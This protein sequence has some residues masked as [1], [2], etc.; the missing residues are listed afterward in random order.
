MEKRVDEAVFTGQPAKALETELALVIE[1]PRTF[2]HRHTYG[3]L[4]PF[5]R[6]LQEGRLL[7]TRCNNPRCL[8]NRLW[9]PARADCPDCH[10]P[11]GWEEIPKPII[12]TIYTYTKVAYGGMGLEISEPYWQIDIELPGVCTIFKS[13]L[14]YGEPRIGMKVRAEFQK[15]PTNT[16]L[17]V[18]WVPHEKSYMCP[19]RK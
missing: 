5:F 19:D 18:Y 8:E 17:N 9:L 14:K 1:W 15:V 7:A 10:Q 4:T 3:K 12:G 6:G 11:M 16:I 13:W 2:V